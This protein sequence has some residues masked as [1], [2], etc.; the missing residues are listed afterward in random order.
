MSPTP[1]IDRGLER[2]AALLDRLDPVIDG[3]CE[4][5]GCIH[6]SHH[7][8]RLAAAGGGAV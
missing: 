2:V 1:I 5:A 6:H 8:P 4:V 7:E 3:A